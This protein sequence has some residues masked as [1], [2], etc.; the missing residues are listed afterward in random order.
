MIPRLFDKAEMAFTGGGLGALAD[1]TRCVVTEELNK[2]FELEMDYPITGKLFKY[3]QLENII[4]AIPAEG[5]EPQPFRIYYIEKRING[6]VT[7]HAEHIV[8]ILTKAVTAPISGRMTPQEL[9]SAINMWTYPHTDI[10]IMTTMQQVA[11]RLVEWKDPRTTWSCLVGAEDSIVHIFSDGWSGGE[12]KFDKWS[13]TLMESRGAQTDFSVNYGREMTDFENSNDL[14]NVYTA[15]MPYWHDKDGNTRRLSDLGQYDDIVESEFTPLYNTTFIAPV[16][17]T[18]FFDENLTSAQL[19]KRMQEQ[20]IRNIMD[21]LAFHVK[22]NT[23]IEFVPLYQTGEYKDIPLSHA[24]LGDIITVNYRQID[25]GSSAK[26]VRTEYD[27]LKGRYI[28]IDIGANREDF[29]QVIYKIAK[30]SK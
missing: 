17:L 30:R 14:T 1:A 25:F 27:V 13:A 28:S 3:L 22:E 26:V 21:N 15:V 16:D 12:W 7:V 24:N 4:F 18:E 2:S 20:A 23:R 10:L 19:A 6:I 29:V 9:V 8:Y 5:E 11:A